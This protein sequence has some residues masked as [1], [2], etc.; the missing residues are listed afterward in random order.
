MIAVQAVRHFVTMA[1]GRF[2]VEEDVDLAR[3]LEFASPVYRLELDFIGRL[4]AQDSKLYTEIMLATPERRGAIARLGRSFAKLA[5]LAESG[6]TDAVGAEFE[7]VKAA[8]GGE[9]ARALEE[10]NEVIRMFG[11]VLAARRKGK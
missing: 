6:D 2:L 10:S 3:S 9:T 8:L 5:A 7:R 4:F 11:E 1:L